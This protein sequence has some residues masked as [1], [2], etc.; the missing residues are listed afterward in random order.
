[1]IIKLIILIIS[2][3]LPIDFWTSKGMSLPLTSSFR[4]FLLFERDCK[5]ALP[6]IKP[7]EFQRKSEITDKMKYVLTTHKTHFFLEDMPIKNVFDSNYDY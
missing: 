7:I 1:M 3:Y 2:I 6:P 4:I 5:I